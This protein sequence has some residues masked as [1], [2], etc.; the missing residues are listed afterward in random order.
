MGVPWLDES[1]IDQA[2]V[3]L[4]AAVGL[5]DGWP[6]FKGIAIRTSV[7]DGQAD[8]LLATTGAGA[9]TRFMLAPARSAT[10]NVHTRLLPYRGPDGP[11]MQDA[12]P[13]DEGRFTLPRATL[14]GPWHTCRQLNT[15]VP[16]PGNHPFIPD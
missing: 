1:G 8:L 2:L 12:V 3:R 10:G 5:P 15:F 16:H 9:M 13:A 4:S 14:T 7:P 11:V 6:D